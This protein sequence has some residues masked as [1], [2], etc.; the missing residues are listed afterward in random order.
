MQD[1]LV[2]NA[3]ESLR[4]SFE[5]AITGFL[6]VLV[7]ALYPYTGDPT[8]DVKKLLIAWA[9]LGLGSA[10]L[11]MAWWHRVPLRRP[12]LFAWPLAGFLGL[13]LFAAT[14][15]S[16][17]T[18]GYLETAR[19]AALAALYFVASQVY[20][21]PEAFDRLLKSLVLASC[22][23]TLYG[24]LQAGGFD[25]VPWDAADKLTDIYTGLPAAYGNPN[26]AAH[27][28]VLTIPMTAY[29]LLR[30]RSWPWMI[31][32]VAQVLH[33]GMTGQRASYIAFAAAISL[34]VVAWTVLRRSAP[35][36]SAVLR[37]LVTWG[38]LGLVALSAGMGLLQWRTGSPLPLDTSL[39]V[40]YWSYVSAVDMLKDA[41]LLGHGPGA[42]EF[43]YH[44]YWSQLEKEWFVQE[45]RKNQ[46][47]HND[48]MEVAIDAG[49]P[50][51]GLYLLM[52]AIGVCAGIAYAARQRG[53]NQWRGLLIAGLFTGFFID[54]LFGFTLRV[55]VS[56][57][58]F[59]LLLGALDGMLGDDAPVPQRRQWR[60]RS[61]A[62]IVA[63]LVIAISRTCVFA[64][65]YQLALAQQAL[66]GMKLD[67]ALDHVK[68]GEILAPWNAQFPLQ[69]AKL[70]FLNKDLTT[71]LA[72]LDR[73]FEHDPN[74]FPAR[75]LQARC[76]VLQAQQVLRSNP[77][78]LDTP[79]A[80][81]EH[82]TA[83]AQKVIDICGE[84]PEA[85]VV[86]GS[87]ATAMAFAIT[88]KDPKGGAAAAKP[89]W[90]SAEEHLE[91]AVR[92]QGGD[93]GELYRMQA[94]VKM[95]LN[96]PAEAEEAY[97][98]AAKAD[99]T[100]PVSWGQFLAFANGNKRYERIRNTLVAVIGTLVKAEK[101]RPDVLSLVRLCLANVLE[102]GYMDYA[103]AEQEYRFAATLTPLSPEVW[104]NFGRFAYQR[105]RVEGFKE[106]LVAARKQLNEE[107]SE[108]PPSLSVAFAT[109]EFDSKAFEDASAVLL[110]RVREYDDSKMTVTQRYE[111]VARLMIDKL[112][113]VPAQQQCV[114]RLNLGIIYLNFKEFSRADAILAGAMQCLPPELVATHAVMWSEALLELNRGLEALNL[115]QP[116]RASADSNFDVRHA[117]ARALV[118]TGKIPEARDEYNA[119]L[120]EPGLGSAGRTV[121]EEELKALQ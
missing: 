53:E 50:A 68:Q 43:S 78:D 102:N 103:R 32:I 99:P 89:Y 27:V 119:L 35:A 19:F 96:K 30:A 81:I 1:T 90:L 20:T 63:L 67:S 105:D 12:G 87:G 29:L 100:D 62:A 56:A 72:E 40:R 92:G 8:G 110:A 117:Y 48:L 116:I 57:T 13:Y 75:L 111:W 113:S 70:A 21:T 23:G 121:L 58:Y 66:H 112:Q 98:R 59:F 14:F 34:V 46:H 39:H 80:L 45:G 101:P 16:Y 93:K 7:L 104:S 25:P 85:E 52:L 31:V 97:E 17:T 82:G 26:F 109:L 115:L 107:K 114:A 77:G 73:T 49:V 28:M 6:F 95:A 55:P 3:H 83:E 47:V 33:L 91:R 64:G 36:R 41:P 60:T 11:S 86:Q 51:A 88:A 94:Q 54:G 5:K 74:L 4:R 118:K 37:S 42:Y 120:Q 84:Y 65:E 10:W 24:F 79:R 38:I 106:A 69:R 108:I 61:T 9:A 15:S 18:I 76:L 71:A 2:P 22:A 44:K